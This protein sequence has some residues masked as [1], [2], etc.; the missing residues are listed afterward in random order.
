MPFDLLLNSLLVEQ[1]LHN[2][3]ATPFCIPKLEGK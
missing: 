1:I 3:K 2:L